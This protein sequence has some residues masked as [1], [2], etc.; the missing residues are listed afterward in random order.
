MKKFPVGIQVYSVR[1]YAQENFY[2]TMTKL[3]NMGYDFVELAG[4]YDMTSD[5]VKSI[6]NELDLPAISAHVP[7]DELINDT[8]STIEKYAHIGCKYIVIPYLTEELRPGTSGFSKVLESIPHI[9][10]ECSKY[11]IT[12][13]YHNHDFEFFKMPDG[14]YAL[15]YMYRTIPTDILQTELDTC[16]IKVAGENPSKYIIKY[17]DRCPI[18]HLKDFYLEGNPKNL[19]ELIGIQNENTDNS[20]NGKFEFRSVGNG[21]QNIPEIISASEEGNAQYLVVE[22]DVS[23]GCTS[24]ES[25][26]LSRKYLRSLGI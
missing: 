16:W 11:N 7:Y 6:L 10:K 8:A 5:K 23:V 21:M 22:Q 26:Q 14:E 25:A 12:L 3:K 20:N 2:D 24:L 18:V 13:L 19:Y 17:K 1:D 15:D 4:L 9:G